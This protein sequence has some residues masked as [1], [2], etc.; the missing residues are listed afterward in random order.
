[1]YTLEAKKWQTVVNNFSGGNQ[2]CEI[3]CETSVAVFQTLKI[4][5]LPPTCQREFSAV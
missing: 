1:M 2:Q 5:G 4:Y 3:V